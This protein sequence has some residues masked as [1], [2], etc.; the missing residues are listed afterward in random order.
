MEAFGGCFSTLINTILLG[1]VYLVGVG[2]T[3][4]MAKIG[5]KEFLSI[6]KLNAQSY[7]QPL[8]L[9]KKT[10]EEYYRQF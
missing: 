4:I 10:T 6:K 8:H 9:K 3:A 1:V 5:K 7:W 2:V